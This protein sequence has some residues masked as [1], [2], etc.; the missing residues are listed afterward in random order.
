MIDFPAKKSEIDFSPKGQ[1][2]ETRGLGKH[3]RVTKVF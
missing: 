2:G 3:K 1:W